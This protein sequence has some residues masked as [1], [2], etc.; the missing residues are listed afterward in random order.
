[1]MFDAAVHVSYA[2]SFRPPIPAA[3]GIDYSVR[4]LASHELNL[5][6][7]VNVRSPRGH[8]TKPRTAWEV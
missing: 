3:T 8:R 2:H 7:L 4:H 1:M 5:S 6:R